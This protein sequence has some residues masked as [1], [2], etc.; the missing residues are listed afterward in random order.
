SS[1]RRSSV[2]SPSSPWSWPPP[3]TRSRRV[4][5]SWT[6][7]STCC[8][9]SCNETLPDPLGEADDP[10]AL[11][12]S[13]HGTGMVGGA[14]PGDGVTGGLTGQDGQAGDDGPGTADASA[15]GH[16]DPLPGPGPVVGRADGRHGAFEVARQQEVG[17]GDPVLRPGQFLPVAATQ[18]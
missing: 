3:T 14:S 16:L 9:A 11:P 4:T 18:P 17:P 6:W 13:F 5:R 7:R 15:A 1:R 2:P 8:A 12:G 10:S